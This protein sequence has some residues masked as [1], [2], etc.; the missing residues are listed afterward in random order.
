[1]IKKTL[2]EALKNHWKL[3]KN[4]KRNF[5]HVFLAHVSFKQKKG[6]KTHHGRE[7][8]KNG[9]Y[10]NCKQNS[11]LLLLFYRGRYIYYYVGAEKC[12]LWIFII[13]KYVFIYANTHFFIYKKVQKKMFV[14]CEG[15]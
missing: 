2:E 12:K 8:E 3:F 5:L 11:L 9:N 15:A 14:V 6:W 10:K 1:M 7:S 13:Y 4:F